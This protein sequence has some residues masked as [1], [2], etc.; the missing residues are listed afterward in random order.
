MCLCRSN[1]ST[2]EDEYDPQDGLLREFAKSRGL[3]D[4]GN[5]A[6]WAWDGSMFRLA[7]YLALD[8]CMGGPPGTFL[9]RWQTAN[10]PVSPDE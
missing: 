8:R 5:S 9:S 1:P 7:S 3:G 4:C 10:D 2:V 6:S